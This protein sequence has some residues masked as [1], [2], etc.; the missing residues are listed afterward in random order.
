[1]KRITVV[2]T[3]TNFQ[4]HT[5]TMSV[6]KN[7]KKLAVDHLVMDEIFDHVVDDYSWEE[8]KGVNNEN[9]N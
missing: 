7:E 1:M 8:L 9:R 5:F 3:D 2:W 6:P 4:K